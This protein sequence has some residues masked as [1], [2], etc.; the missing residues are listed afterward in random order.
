MKMN[1]IAQ[2]GLQSI[3]KTAIQRLVGAAL[4]IC[5]LV[6]LPAAHAQL[7][8]GSIA[9]TVKDPSGAF[10]AN[11]QIKARDAE[12]GFEFS[13][14]SDSAG[15]YVIRELPPSNYTVTASATGFKT[16]RRDS[17]RIDVNQNASVDFSMAVGAIAEVVDVRAGAVE[18]QTEDAE[19]G[20]VVNRKFIN[21]LPLIDRN[22]ETL[23]SLAPGVTEMND[24]CPEPCIGTNFVSN[25]SRGASADFLLDGASA[26]NSEPNGGI[27]SVTY[28]PSPEA[29]EEFKVQQTNFSAE[30]GFSGASV[31]NVVSRSG[32]NKFHGS[33]YEF[34]RNDSLDANDWFANHFGNPIP[35]LRRHNYGGTIGGPIFKNRTFFFFD[36]DYLT[37]NGAS[38]A[39]AGVPSDAMR[40]GD[41][42]EL[43]ATE[44]GTF[45]GSGRCS[46]DAGQ[47]WDPWSG[48]FNNGLGGPLR[49]AF[50]PFNNIATYASPSGPGGL[51]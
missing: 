9:G 30:Y 10:L 40:A 12:K 36:Y 18:L 32:T 6:W 11:A 15:R 34:F 22:I 25:G 37:E 39:Q 33:V 47:I 1:F 28:L 41:F 17:V 50:I 46:T 31:V 48:V 42:G 44:G 7:Y 26:T 5:A 23:T 4:A 8:T 13:A 16:Q 24:S 14:T 35:P 38:T 19:T 49:S 29:V 43:C 2:Y 20:Q 51:A 45:N 21:D 3:S 27:T